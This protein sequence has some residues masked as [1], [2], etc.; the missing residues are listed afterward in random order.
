MGPV[1]VRRMQVSAHIPGTVGGVHGAVRSAPPLLAVGSATLGR[2]CQLPI[3][4]LALRTF[5]RCINETALY[6][7]PFHLRCYCAAAGGYE[8]GHPSRLQRCK[9]HG[10]VREAAEGGIGGFCVLRIQVEYVRNS[11]TAIR[12]ACVCTCRR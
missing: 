1:T 2:G 6:A 4:K 8:V 11:S 5:C 10:S 7:R 12:A 9:V 3:A